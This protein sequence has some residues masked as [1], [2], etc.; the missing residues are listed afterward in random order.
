MSVEKTVEQYVAVHNKA[1]WIF[2]IYTSCRPFKRS[3]SPPELQGQYQRVSL[4][5]FSFCQHFGTGRLQS[6]C[7]SQQIN[8]S[9]LW[10]LETSGLQFLLIS[11]FSSIWGMCHLWKKWQCC[12][13][14]QRAQQEI[15]GFSTHVSHVEKILHQEQKGFL[16]LVSVQSAI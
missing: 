14:L 13:S 5:L 8:I 4:P 9:F 2:S 12:H 11:K 1:T 7:S 16:A 10:W 15:L 6:I 3:P